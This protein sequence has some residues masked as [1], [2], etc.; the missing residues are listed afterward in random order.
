MESLVER[1]RKRV[2]YL[3]TNKPES[4]DLSTYGHRHA[5]QRAAKGDFQAGPN[6]RQ[7]RQKS[8]NT[9]SYGWSQIKITKL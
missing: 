5:D 8:S 4:I 9:G 7:D 1:L 6:T 2:E 3:K